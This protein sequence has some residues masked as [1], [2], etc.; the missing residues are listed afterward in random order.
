MVT[1]N[2]SNPSFMTLGLFFG[3]SFTY[4]KSND[5]EVESTYQKTSYN[6][7]GSHHSNLVN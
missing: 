1:E 2:P 7:W 4:D 5:F 3:T 6:Q